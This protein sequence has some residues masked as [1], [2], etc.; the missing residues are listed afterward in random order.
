MKP[1]SD[2]VA[3]RLAMRACSGDNHPLTWVHGLH[4][5]E[6]VQ[7]RASL[8]EREVSGEHLNVFMVQR[9]LPGSRNAVDGGRRRLG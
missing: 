2:L 9:L 5:A 6:K 7:L 1:P 3:S 8:D 4:C